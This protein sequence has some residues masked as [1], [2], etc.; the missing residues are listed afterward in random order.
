MLDGLRLGIMLCWRRG[1]FGKL[2]Q[3]GLKVTWLAPAVNSLQTGDFERWH[4]GPLIY[5]GNRRGAVFTDALPPFTTVQRS[6]RA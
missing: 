6:R 2:L 1:R 5:E 3:S 4:Q